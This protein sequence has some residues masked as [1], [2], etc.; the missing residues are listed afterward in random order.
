MAEVI[1]TEPALADLEAIAEYIALDNPKAAREFVQRV[2]YRHQK[3]LVYLV[4]VARESARKT[5]SVTW[6]ASPVDLAFG[7]N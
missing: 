5:N 7:S 3:S 6:K 2:I 4:H 1:W